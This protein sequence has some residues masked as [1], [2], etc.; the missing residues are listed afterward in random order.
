ML[1]P[2]IN[3]VKNLTAGEIEEEDRIMAAEALRILKDPAKEKEM[4]GAALRR[5]EAFPWAAMWNV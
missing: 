4:G 5:S 3:P 1:L 2:V